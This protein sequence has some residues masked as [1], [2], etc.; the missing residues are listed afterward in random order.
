MM[1]VSNVIAA[2]CY[3]VNEVGKNEE[4]QKA[5]QEFQDALA[6]LPTWFWVLFLL[7]VGIAWSLFS[8]RRR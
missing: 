3:G 2:G 1:I 8:H 6:S 4:C 7:G 5:R